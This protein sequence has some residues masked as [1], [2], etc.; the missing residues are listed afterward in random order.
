MHKWHR[1][2][3]GVIANSSIERHPQGL[4]VPFVG[5]NTKWIQPYNDLYPSGVRLQMID[6]YQGLCPSWLVGANAGLKYKGHVNMPTEGLELLHGLQQSSLQ[7][8]TLWFEGERLDEGHKATRTCFPMNRL[9]LC[10]VGAAT[11]YK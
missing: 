2:R 6:T 3:I 1:P 11:L 5:Y 7:D 8:T 4:P 10:R 9:R